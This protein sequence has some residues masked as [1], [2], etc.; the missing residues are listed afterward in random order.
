MSKHFLEAYVSEDGANFRI[1][2][3]DIKTC[4]V[5]ENYPIGCI[6]KNQW[7]SHNVDMLDWKGPE[8]V[9]GRIEVKAYVESPRDESQAWV[10]APD[11]PTSPQAP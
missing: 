11:S 3:E 7:Q 6:Y 9:L 2:C 4:R 8:I 5:E 10:T 1:L